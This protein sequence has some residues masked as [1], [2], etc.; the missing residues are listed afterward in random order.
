[1]DELVERRDPGPAEVALLRQRAGDERHLIYLYDRANGPGWFRALRADPLL[2]PPSEGPWSAGPYVERVAKTH[3]DEVAAW[4]SGFAASDLTATQVRY[5][6]LIARAISADVAGVALSLA[7]GHLSSPDV[8]FQLDALLREMSES[9]RAG[10]AAR[11]LVR[12]SLMQTLTERSGSMDT[13]MAAEQLRMAVE[14]IRLGDAQK[15]LTMLAHRAKEVAEATDALRMRVLAQLDALHIDISREPLELVAAALRQGANVGATVGVP[16]EQRLSTLEIVPDPLARRLIAQHLLDHVPESLT[17]SVAFLSQ[18][19]AANE[20][21]S[22]EELALLRRVLSEGSRDV[23]ADMVTALGPVPTLENVQ[24]EASTRATSADLIRAHRWLVAFPS[25]AVSSWYAV[26]AELSTHLGPAPT[27]GVLIRRPDSQFVG[28]VTPITVEELA[29]LPPQEAAKKVAA[30][31]PEPDSSFFGPSSEGL[32]DTLRRAMDADTQRWIDADPVEIARL[33]HHPIYIS[34][35]L[36]ALEANAS[37]LAGVAERIVTLAELLQSEPW[38]IADL[39][40][41]RL[42]ASDLWSR[43]RQE[44]IKLLGRL[45]RLGELQGEMADRA[46][47][48]VVAA[49][50]HRDDTS[51]NIEDQ[52]LKPLEAAFV[53]PSMR[54][55][56]TAI[57][58]G[59]GA[60]PTPDKRLLELIDELL[61]LDGVDGLHSRAMLAPQLNWL[62]S[63]SPDWFADHE[64]QL[65]GDAAPDDLG[66]ATF[67]LYLQW[68]DPYEPML[69]EQRD[70]II[71]ALAGDDSDDAA[72]HLLHGLLWKLPGYEVE[73]VCDILVQAGTRHVSY[74]GRWLG[75]GLAEAQKVD[76]TP[77]AALWRELLERRLDADAYAG[78]GWMAVNHDLDNDQWLTLTDDTAAATAGVLDEPYRVAERA[79]QTPSDPRAA[80]IIAQ[81]LGD[82]PAPSDMS[83]IGEVGVEVLRGAT[84][85]PRE[86]LRERLLERGFHAA[87]DM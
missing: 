87:V 58:I 47:A 32:A 23:A 41:H 17:E 69:L 35:W 2:L 24:R 29:A 37:R 8:R 31:R 59:G 4:L 1:M 42:P 11:S 55:L 38:A 61:A 63:G 68:G 66:K 22:P 43:T 75:R 9:A 65:F 72:R 19:I 21:P 34:V 36:Q 12:Q 85:P 33:L 78:F 49:V 39:G 50:R 82:D 51:A 40:R 74:A 53:R 83:R 5:L 14:A 81:L 15:W 13:Y 62:R 64:P 70:R 18:Q 77:V 26:D 79:G 6:L 27:D 56:E 20:W 25:A 73:T 3:P 54:A 44:S 60:T 57:E 71:A 48:Q 86:T 46:W 67:E 16:L 52:T 80:K 84:G 7:R 45:A 28:P 76:Q 10:P 30:W